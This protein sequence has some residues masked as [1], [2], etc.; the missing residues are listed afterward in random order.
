MLKDK[1]VIYSLT[2]PVEVLAKRV[3][4]KLDAEKSF[5]PQKSV[6]NKGKNRVQDP[7]SQA[8]LALQ[9]DFL[10]IDWS[11]EFEFPNLS[12]EDMSKLLV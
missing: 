4:E 11:E 3:Q 2:K 9:D 6:G 5:E 10:T 1:K 7:V 12:L 8:L